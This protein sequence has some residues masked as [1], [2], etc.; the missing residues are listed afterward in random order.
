MRS[1]GQGG[2]INEFSE[3]KKKNWKEERKKNCLRAHRHASLTTSDLFR[4]MIKISI[5]LR[6]PN[7]DMTHKY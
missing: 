3:K 1:K 7:N 5:N 2:R 6:R 4:G